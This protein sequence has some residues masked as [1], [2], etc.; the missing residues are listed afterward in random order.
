MLVGLGGGIRRT[1]FADG[2]SGGLFLVELGEGGN[3]G[4]RFVVAAARCFVEAE[5][6]KGSSESEEEDCRGD[7]DAGVEMDLANDFQDLVGR[8]HKDCDRF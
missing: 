4:G 1:L 5:G 3:P 7:E 8:G 2:D 6:L